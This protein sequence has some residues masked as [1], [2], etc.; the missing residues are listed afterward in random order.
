MRKN[1]ELKKKK[2]NE[3]DREETKNSL[4]S[5]NRKGPTDQAVL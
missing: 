1:Y 2:N 3:H 4:T 5:S